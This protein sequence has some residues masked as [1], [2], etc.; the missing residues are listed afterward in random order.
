MTVGHIPR[1]LPHEL[2]TLYVTHPHFRDVLVEAREDAALV[3]WYLGTL[4]IPHVK[5]FA[6][7]DRVEIDADTVREH[8]REV[9]KRGRVVAMSALSQSWNLAEPSV[10]CVVDADFAVLDKECSLDD[11]LI[12]TDYPAIENYSLAD[13]PLEKFLRVVA[14]S[15]LSPGEVRAAL[16]PVWVALYCLRYVLH[17]HTDGA[18][19]ISKFAERCISESG[20]VALDVPRLLRDSTPGLEAATREELVRLYESAVAS[21]PAQELQ[22]IRGHDIA[23]ILARYLNLPSSIRSPEILE[24]LLRQ[25]VEKADW[26]EQP[27][28]HKL[29]DRVS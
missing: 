28:M 26:D 6:I 9:N 8:H 4:S 10:T 13:R 18:S 3:E 14:R 12:H 16:R 1:R 25:C 22:G 21:V 15:S 5:A 24:R 19:L 17:R 20:V 11:S 2:R 7:D 27:L 23:P 29:R